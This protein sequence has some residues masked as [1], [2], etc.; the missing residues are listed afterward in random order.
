VP[1]IRITVLSTKHRCCVLTGRSLTHILFASIHSSAA[2][3]CCVTAALKWYDKL[4]DSLSTFHLVAAF[5]PNMYEEEPAPGSPFVEYEIESTTWSG[6]LQRW[7]VARIN[8]LIHVGLSILIPIV[9]LIVFLGL[10][11]G[12]SVVI[13]LYLRRALV[14]KALIHEQVF[15]NYVMDPPTAVV[16]FDSSFKQWEYLR[17]PD[18]GGT[19]PGTAR[20]LRVQRGYDIHCTV[21]VAKSARNFDISLTPITLKLVDATGE[22]LASSSRAIVI[23]YQHPMSLLLESVTFF[24]WRATR[25]VDR[26]ETVDV[27]VDLMREY[28]EPGLTRPP[29]EALELTLSPPVM[30]IS[31]AHVT[32]MPQLTGIT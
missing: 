28:K 26:A 4:P 21:T 18:K 9:Q 20:F 15:F 3:L 22:T 27:W 13:N 7:I 10:V 5:S 6:R 8:R 23:P 17:T 16:R 31:Y 1:N 12:I 19:L 25:Y 29:A 32:V 24:P 30:D 14:P 2:L 11:V